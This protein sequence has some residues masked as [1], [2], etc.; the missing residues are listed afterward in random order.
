MMA[1]HL[2][3]AYDDVFYRTHDGLTLYACDY[4]GDDNRPVLLCLHGLTRNSADFHDLA[5]ELSD[6][7]IISPDQRGRG[8][9]DRDSNIE[10]YRPELYC[11]DMISLL[12]ELK[13]GQVIVIGTSMGGLMSMIMPMLR[14]GVFKAVIM[15]DIG[16]E[17]DDRGLQRFA[18]LCRAKRPV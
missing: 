17:V 3:R 16:P 2:T 13:V 8:R 15:N 1:S 6:Y 5:V 18:K 14:P 7:R 4:P 10:N 12:D 9:S 11:Q